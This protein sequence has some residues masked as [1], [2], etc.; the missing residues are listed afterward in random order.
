MTEE[1]QAQTEA[2]FLD[3]DALTPEA[4][5]TIQLNNKKHVMSEMTVQ[6]FV[7]AQQMAGRTKEIE[8]EDDE[9]QAE[10]LSQMIDIL[11]RQFPTA[12]REAIA[13]L[14]LRKLMALIKFTG[15]LGS[16]GAEV[17][18]AEAAADGGKVTVVEREESADQ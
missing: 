18:V 17:A 10:M 16:E 3:L 12:G 6:D 11:A 13:N 15:Q 1:T 8:D 14:P 5:I 2:Q 4:E 9:A 7:W